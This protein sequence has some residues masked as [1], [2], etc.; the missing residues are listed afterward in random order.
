MIVPLLIAL[1]FAPWSN[2]DPPQYDVLVYGSTPGGIQAAISASFEGASVALV[3]SSARVGGM[4]TSGLGHTDKG[5]P[6]AIGG[7]ALKFFHDVCTAADVPPCWDFP[8]SR[9]VALFQRMLASA[10]NVT[11]IH[12]YSVAG[13]TRN[14]S[15]V[16][17]ILLTSL[18]PQAARRLH[19]NITA[20][21]FI[22]ASYEGDLIAAA[23]ISTAIG[24]EARS[25]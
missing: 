17:S 19:M 16:T 5:N 10:P 15:T 18:A 25:M 22:D 2:A 21:Y 20:D 13:V 8:P 23:S 7:A 1:A 6:K 4:M 12:E 24:R 3:S 11:L 9:A 14:G